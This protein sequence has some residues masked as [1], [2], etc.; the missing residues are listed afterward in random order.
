MYD[1]GKVTWT[2]GGAFDASA[3]YEINTVVTYNGSAYLTLKELTGTTPADD[4]VNYRLVV[5]KGDT[6]VGFSLKN[7]DVEIGGNVDYLNTPLAGGLNFVLNSNNNRV[8]LSIQ[9]SFINNTAS[10]IKINGTQSAG[11]LNSFS[12]ADHIHPT[13]TSRLSSAAGMVLNENIA[14]GAITLSK[15]GFTN[16]AGI[17]NSLCR[18]K[19][20]GTSVTA[21][22]YE[23]I[24]AGTFDDLWLEDYFTIN[25][26]I[27]RIAHFD[28]YWNVGDTN[29]Q[30][31]HITL[32]PE[33][34]FYNARMNASN[35][36]TGAYVGSEM[37]TANLAT[38]LATVISAF[39]S[40]HILNHRV[41][42]PNAVSS[43]TESGWAW[44][45]SKIELM[46][47]MQVYGARA[48]GAKNEN[49]YSVGSQNGQFAA[50]GLNHN[51]IHN[52]ESYWLQDVAS[53]SSFASVY[54]LGFAC[55]GGSSDSLG[56]RPAFS[57][58]A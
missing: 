31:H 55:G 53:S 52:R 30:T 4:G 50:F 39:G 49:G 12:R 13:D 25:S 14:D 27:F 29:C 37:Y 18:G 9:D 51:R 41:L 5:A 46:N 38:A 36:V 16:N 11:V 2:N 45:D 57:I 17:H 32:I 56:V 21:A 23:A 47:E 34:S 15:L 48:W 7:D 20:L 22:Q 3:T 24:A 28:Y 10:N 43:G 54:D 40:S 44:F 6:G 35:I 33:L 19:S 8:D 58:C 42:L 26:I 1:L